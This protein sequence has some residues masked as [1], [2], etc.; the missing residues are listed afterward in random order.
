MQSKYPPDHPMHPSNSLLY[1]VLN[2][3]GY[4]LQ[5]IILLGIFIYLFLWPLFA[6]TG[7]APV[8]D[9]GV[10]MVSCQRDASVIAHQG[11]HR[12]VYLQTGACQPGRCVAFGA[13]AS[14]SFV[15]GEGAPGEPL[16]TYTAG[17]TGLLI[18]PGAGVY[19]A[20]WENPL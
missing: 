15:Y 9:G 3:G 5:A 4:I 2:I 12:V 16:E 10:G 1:M 7:C 17:D 8:D 19:S 14:P 20:L 11:G 6:L 13:L 18:C